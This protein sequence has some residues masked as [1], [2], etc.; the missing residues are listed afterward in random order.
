MPFLTTHS[1]QKPSWL[2]YTLVLMA[3]AA[4]T[5]VV[6]VRWNLFAFAQMAHVLAT[7]VAQAVDAVDYPIISLM[8][9]YARRSW[10]LDTLFYLIDGNPL[11]TAP[12]LAAFW[13][14]WFKE[15]EDA[16]RNREFLL[17][18]LLSS[19]LSPVVVRFVSLLAPYRDRPLHNAQL[20]FQLPYNMNPYR[21]IGWSSFPSDHGAVWFSLAAAVFLVSRRL[22]VL[23]FL[24]VC[25]TLAPA[26][27]Y[28]G[29]HYPSD[30][31]AGGLIGVA[32]VSLVKYP[33]FRTT[34]TRWPLECL[35]RWPQVFYVCFFLITAEMVEG[36]S[37]VHDL[38]GY[39]SAILKA[40]LHR[41]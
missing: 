1:R 34:V 3:V 27:I 37:S 30:I 28:L 13:W 26:R 4:V 40:L 20:H 12:L 17:G 5:A 41:V 6:L 9:S 29:I 11:A 23:S 31:L 33:A 7:S 15:G 8:N 24:Y 10:S 32:M 19:F 36:F 18:G 22:G 25:F 39:F 38:Q 2:L 16:A 35:R 21:L 14:A